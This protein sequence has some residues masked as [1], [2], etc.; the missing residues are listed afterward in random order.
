MTTQE[1]DKL[2]NDF[3]EEFP[4]ERL[5]NLSLEEYTNLEKSN[6]F[7]YWLETRTENLGSI[8]GAFSDKF[9]IYRCRNERKGGKKFISDGVY[10][11]HKS[12][13]NNAQ[14]AFEQVR[15]KILQVAICA[16]NAEFEKIDD[17]DLLWP[18]YKWKIAFLYSNQKLLPMY[19]EK[20]LKWI[21]K[22]QGLEVSPKTKI[23]QIQAFLMSKKG[24]SDV[25]SYAKSLWDE[26]LGSDEYKKSK[27]NNEETA[28]KNELVDEILSILRYKK[29]IILQGA[30]GVGKTFIT[31]Q[32]ALRFCGVSVDFS[33]YDE[34][35]SKYE[36]LQKSGQIG[37]VTFHQSMDYEDFVEGIKPEITEN[38]NVSYEVKD[39][40]FK[41]ICQSAIYGNGGSDNFKIAWRK[42]IEKLNETE[43][44]E[45][46]LLSNENKKIR[47][48]LNEYGTGLATR[49]YEN[50][51]FKKDNWI[52]GKS[53][54][55][56]Y[57]Q[58]YNV[59]IGLPG[60]PSGGHD[61]YRKAIV[62]E[63][64]KNFGLQNYVDN[65]SELPKPHVLIIDEINR[66]NISKIFGEL[67]T[68]LE[69]DKRLG[70]EHPLRVTLPYSKK[71]FGIPNNLYIIGTM[72]TTDR[73][74]G[75][76]DY[77]VRRRF[78]FVTLPADENTI[79]GDKNQKLFN[80]VKNFIESNNSSEIDL[81]DL[82]VGH[83]Y[84]MSDDENELR[85]KLKYE[86]LPLLDEYYKDGILKNKPN[87][88]D[89]YKILDNE[90]SDN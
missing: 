63:M 10:A 30:P 5:E 53:K 70:G 15:K 17:I 67:I 8:W 39:G 89:F 3:L 51:E 33:K 11:W 9:G 81:D 55:Y 22:K 60:I 4:I 78:A 19:Q 80:A 14:E 86:I 83:S 49:T 32:L 1:K 54:F 90:S 40:I 23:S 36:E 50:D 24:D 84:F 68:L 38:G 41:E 16:K 75:S 56:N 31:A 6:S 44:I 88:N 42:L 27:E 74:V 37:F 47:I 12:Y 69:S 26:W 59:Y 29:N 34:V 43:I 35:M 20:G 61:N 7:C 66:G 46:P 62:A 58:L 77:A 45:V 48:E 13:G 2:Y 76:I 18:L 85:L 52:K 28:V 57:D 25:F 73:S 82:M 87:A 64:K 79:K 21:A 65:K 71:D 72:N